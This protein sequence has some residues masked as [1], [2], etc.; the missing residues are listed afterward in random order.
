MKKPKNLLILLVSLILVFAALLVN[1]QKKLNPVPKPAP[2][3]PPRGSQPADNPMVLLAKTQNYSAARVSSYQ[4][5]GGPRDNFW[6]PTTG[7]ETTLAEIKGPGAITHIWSTS[8]CSGRDLIIR[9]YWDGSEHPSVEAPYGDFFGVAMDVNANM[10]SYPIHVSSEG[11][12]RNCWWYM[13]FNRSA[14]IT[15]TATRS[16]ANQQSDTVPLYFYIDYQ[17]YAEPI[18]D[19]NY[20]HAQFLETDPPVR[21]K[22]VTLLD[23][24][25]AGHFIGVVMG[26]RA[27][28]PGWF[29]EGD[30]IITVDG[31]VSFAG[32]GTEDY[33]SDAYG[34]RVC[35]FPY[36]GVPV[37]E[38]RVIGS[39]LSV[40]RFHILDPIPF[41]KSFK[42]EIEHWPW[43]SPIP[44]TGRGYYSSLGFWYQKKIHKAWPRLETLVSHQPW[45][46][47]KGRWFVTDALE[48][49]NLGILGFESKSGRNARP[50]TEK[51]LPNLSGDFMLVFDSGGDGEFSLSVPAEQAGEYT[52]NVYYPRAPEFGIVELF[53]NGKRAG[54][55]VDNF[56][57]TDNLTRPLWPPKKTVYSGLNLTAGLNTFKFSVKSKNKESEG[58]KVAVDCIVLERVQ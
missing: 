6:I 43:L 29:G 45:D 46:P 3:E 51:V 49:E 20:F 25:G 11:R 41:R 4:P 39:R 42:L 16:E 7:E 37:M 17:V 55:P 2:T 5:E 1:A 27:R 58:Y 56:L 22:N 23:I 48:A 53:I 26:H 38:G 15:A 13:P 52:V 12:S 24:Q 19:I 57:K 32:T 44:N 34:F 31:Q 8:L 47:D 50:Y 10:N 33:F 14:R 35:S 21:G 28:Y 30:D 18:K 9:A 40:Y 36:Y 54:D